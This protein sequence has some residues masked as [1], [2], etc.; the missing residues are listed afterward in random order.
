MASITVATLEERVNNHIRFFWTVVAAG[1]LWMSGLSLAIYHLNDTAN[2]IRT[3]QVGLENTV[4]KQNIIAYSLLPSDNFK[5]ILTDISSVI[6]TAK[7]KNIKVS[8]QVIEDLQGKLNASIDAPGYWPAVAEFISYRSVN[9]TSWVA[10]G[11]LPRCTDSPPT[12]ATVKEILHQGNPTVLSLNPGVYENCRFDLDS[13]QEDELLN[14]FLVGSTP[15]ITFKH[16]VIGY[17][18]GVI[19]ILI[20]L[21]EQDAPISFPGTDMKGVG[22]TIVNN[23]LEFDDCLFDIAFQDVPPRQG[24][25][26]TQF[27]L[28]NQ[29]PIIK[30][31]LSIQPQTPAGL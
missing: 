19:N 29:G 15:M 16:C 22:H 1:F 25:K 26:L 2:Q 28:A 10:P 11:D 14:S 27:L 7:Q 9:N 8:P 4:A 5:A 13:P 24:Q 12:H 6:S 31:P 3:A 30:L 23:T 21:D 18:G 17:R 20:A